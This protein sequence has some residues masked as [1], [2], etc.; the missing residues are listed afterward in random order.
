MACAGAAAAATAG[1]FSRTRMKSSTEP[2]GIWSLALRDPLAAGLSF[3][4]QVPAALGCATVNSPGTFGPVIASFA[5]KEDLL[6]SN[7]HPAEESLTSTLSSVIS[8]RFACESSHAPDRFGCTGAG[9]CAAIRA[10]EL[11]TAIVA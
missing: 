2:S 11:N 7:D 3:I 5:V 6:V 10:M 9:A 1:V 4:I 8:I